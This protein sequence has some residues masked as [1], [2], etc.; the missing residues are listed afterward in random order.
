LI[1]QPDSLS[2]A[3]PIVKR[4]FARLDNSKGGFVATRH[5]GCMVAF[6]GFGIATFGIGVLAAWGTAGGSMISHE[7]KEN[8]VLVRIADLKANFP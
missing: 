8:K 6:A 5:I 3:R 1:L 2:A 4:L 7:I